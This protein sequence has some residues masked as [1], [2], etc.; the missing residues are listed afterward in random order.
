MKP[1]PANRCDVCDQAL[2]A[3]GAP[4]GNTVCNW[5]N[6]QFE[7]NAAVAMRSGELKAAINSYKYGGRRNWSLIFGRVLA[8]FLHDQR[9]LFA[10][11]DLVIPSPTYVGPDGR[12]F[13]HTAL[14]LAEAA[15]LDQTRLPFAL[16]PPVL[17]KTG[18]TMPLVGLS[19]SERRDV[20]QY[21]LPK[22]LHVPDPR[23]VQGKAFLV[24]DDVFTDGL[25][26]NA[27]AK[28]LRQAGASRVCGVTLAR[29]PW[30]SP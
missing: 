28:K 10:G 4:C 27:V 8:G 9:P 22:V 16:D 1:V 17:V 14:V 12:D 23:R 3:P 30:G 29:Q 21:E 13:D 24:Y 5:P 19:W 15:R 25:N 6:R 26:L 2:R 11:F 7:W 18:P 20:C